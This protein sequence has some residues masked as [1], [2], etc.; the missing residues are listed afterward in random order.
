MGADYRHIEGFPGYA[1]GSNGAVWSQLRGSWKQRKTRIDRA[2]YA[3]VRLSRDGKVFEFRVHRL[4]MAAFIGPCPPGYEVAHNDGIRTNANLSNLR[5]DTHKGN[6]S[7][8]L[9]HGTS[10][11]GGANGMAKLTDDAVRAMRR[12]H[13]GGTSK[14][15]LAAAFSVEVRNVNR[16]LR[17]D[18]WGHVK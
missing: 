11:A 18:R 5:Y 2:G 4:V 1:I 17:G 13:R 7:D 3:L 8:R 10:N 14:A 15:D 12:L 6:H 16:V 9:R